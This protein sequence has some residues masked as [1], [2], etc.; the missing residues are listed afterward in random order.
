MNENLLSLSIVSEGEHKG[1]LR[2][3]LTTA[4]ADY[5]LKNDEATLMDLFGQQGK[6]NNFICH[7]N[8]HEIYTEEEVRYEKEPM[9]VSRFKYSGEGYAI[10]DAL[11]KDSFKGEVHFTP[12]EDNAAREEECAQKK[13]AD[14]WG[15]YCQEPLNIA[16]INL[17]ERH[18]LLAKGL[19]KIHE[20]ALM[21]R[22]DKHKK[23]QY[24]VEKLHDLF[25]EIEK[26]VNYTDEKMKLVSVISGRDYNQS[27]PISK[28]Y[29]EYRGINEEQ[30]KQKLNLQNNG[31]ETE[32]A[33]TTDPEGHDD[34]R[35]GES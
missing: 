11:E 8:L 20:A 33:N 29:R 3:E 14:M 2:L 24:Y 30:N 17:Q 13:A 32:N 23:N 19:E 16:C 4:G 21:L 10:L 6:V 35:K 34:I 12:D 7:P 15:V 28:A 31:Q 5:L 22:G 1:S 26:E 25:T 9:V 27:T 18:A